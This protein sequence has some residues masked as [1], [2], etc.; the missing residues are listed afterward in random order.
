[1]V[2]WL[3]VTFT[4]L[5][6]TKVFKC[7]RIKIDILMTNFPSCEVRN[8]LLVTRVNKSTT[9]LRP[10]MEDQICEIRAGVRS[11]TSQELDWI[12]VCIIKQWSNSTAAPLCSLVNHSFTSGPFTSLLKH[13][14]VKPVYIVM[15]WIWRVVCRSRIS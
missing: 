10:S 14:L 11:K 6:V 7:T 9:F 1:M 8:N 4:I 15:P 13:A 12:L 5:K 3:E 2:Y